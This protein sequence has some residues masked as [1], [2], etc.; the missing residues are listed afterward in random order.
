MVIAAIEAVPA[1]DRSDADKRFLQRLKATDARALLGNDVDTY[2]ARVRD[3]LGSSNADVRKAEV[4]RLFE[5]SLE[6]RR[7]VLRDPT[8]RTLDETGGILLFP[9][10]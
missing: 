6:L 2:V 4:R 7:A 5:K 8:F 9:L 10:P 1:A 3:K